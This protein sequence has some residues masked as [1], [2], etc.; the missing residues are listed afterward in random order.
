MGL[1]QQPPPDCL[2]IS[3]LTF[4]LDLDARAVD[5]QVQRAVRAAVGDID[6]QGLL[7]PRQRAEVG[8]RPVQSDQAKEAF[9][10]PDRLPQRHAEQD[11]HGQASLDRGIAIA[12]WRSHLPVGATSSWPAA[13]FVDTKIRS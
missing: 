10:A 13:G 1:F 9:D 4:S 3:P 6:L 7:A 5:Q 2:L 11:V 12:G 8:H